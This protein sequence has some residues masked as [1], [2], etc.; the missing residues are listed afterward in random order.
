MLILLGC[1]HLHSS[2]LNYAQEAGYLDMA[3]SPTCGV[4]Y[5]NELGAPASK[6]YE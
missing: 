4:G 1:I 6:F 3:L 5:Q 2:R